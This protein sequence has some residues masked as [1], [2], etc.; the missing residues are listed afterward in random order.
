MCVPPFFIHA[1]LIIHTIFVYHFNGVVCR[2]GRYFYTVL[3]QK[4]LFLR[5]VLSGGFAVLIGY[6]VHFAQFL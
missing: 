1:F 6:A 3:H 5:Q 2:E 4:G